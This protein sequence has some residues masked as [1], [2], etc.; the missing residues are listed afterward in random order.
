MEQKKKIKILLLEDSP[1]DARLISELISESAPSDFLIR[2]VTLLKDALAELDSA[3][4]YDVVLS[5]LSVTDSSGVET[6]RDLRGHARKLPI[7]ILSGNLDESMAISSVREGAQDYLVKGQPDGP[8]LIRSIR[9]GIERKK[10][11]QE[12]EHLRS[13]QQNSAKMASLGEMAGGVAHEI[14][15]PLGAIL[16]TSQSLKSALE[17]FDPS[18]KESMI[19]MTELIEQTTNRI[20]KIVKSLNTFSRN[21][22]ND[23][24]TEVKLSDI[25]GS[26]VSLCTEKFSHMGIIL[27]I[28]SDSFKNIKL[29]CRE[30]EISQ[31]I[32]NLLTNARDAIESL[33]EKWVKISSRDDGENIEI[34]V[35]DS[36]SGI[37]KEI[38]EKIFNPFFTSKDV[39]KGTGIGLSVSKGIIESHGG[40][41]RVNENAQHTTFLIRL[42]KIQ[43]IAAEKIVMMAS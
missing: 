18:Q 10:S 33:T 17:V 7:I 3:S 13:Q 2:H 30:S 12:L 29:Q 34:T 36:G 5:D 24:F 15:T 37:P 8:S 1:G 21:S 20:A 22:N 32:L 39:G 4:G 40:S 43:K 9:Y 27:E 31:V 16:L 25:V 28:D 23:P 26:A 14:N 38:V 35:E 19:E 41:I 42:P 6:Y 11:E